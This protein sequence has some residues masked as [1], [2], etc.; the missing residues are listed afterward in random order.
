MHISCYCLNNPELGW[1]N[2]SPLSFLPTLAIAS[3][4]AVFHPIP[5]FKPQPSDF[6]WPMIW[7]GCNHV[8]VLDLN[9]KKLRMF[10]TI[11]FASAIPGEEWGP[12]N[13]L[14]P[15][16]W[17][18]CNRVTEA[19][20]QQGETAAALSRAPQVSPASIRQTPVIISGLFKLLMSW[21]YMQNYCGNS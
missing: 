18:K 10:S 16:K 20:N 15:W 13:V 11:C 8:P 6:L 1:P 4:W 21:P 3:S 14:I 2:F 9:L 12:L 5:D 7:S 19:N 17:D